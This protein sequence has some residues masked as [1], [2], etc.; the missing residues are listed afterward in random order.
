M[1]I[2]N[3][4]SSWTR[5]NITRLLELYSLL[6]CFHVQF[7]L[8]VMIYK[9][10][11]AIR[12]CYL[13]NRFSLLTSIHSIRSGRRSMLWVPSTKKFFSDGIQKENL[14]GTL[15]CSLSPKVGIGT[16]FVGSS[17]RHGCDIRSE[18]LLDLG[19]AVLINTLL[20]FMFSG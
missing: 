13:R 5:V 8:L 2:F 10:L 17:W 12:L 6:V 3:Q 16:I 14:S 20:C 9:A 11:N 1:Q 7:K 4:W 15:H 18:D 19:I